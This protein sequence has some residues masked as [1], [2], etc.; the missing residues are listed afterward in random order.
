[1]A[2]KTL[3]EQINLFLEE[4]DISCQIDF[5]KDIFELYE[6][7]NVS[8]E[9]DWMK[10]VV[11]G[12][13]EEINVI[14]LLRT[15]YLLS[16]IASKYAGRFCYIQSKFKDLWKKMEEVESIKFDLKEG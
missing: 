5:L 4:W 9:D 10:E 13:E 3:E 6:L 2:K 1:M 11:E 15:V 12:G 8:Q 7:Y 16:K 14:R